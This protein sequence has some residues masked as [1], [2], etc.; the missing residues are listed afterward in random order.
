MVVKRVSHTTRLPHRT[1]ISKP[2]SPQSE[3]L[4]DSP[5]LLCHT[6]RSVSAFLCVSCIYLKGRSKEIDSYNIQKT[7]SEEMP[8]SPKG[9]LARLKKIF[10]AVRSL[11]LFIF[12]VFS[13][14]IIKVTVR[15]KMCGRPWPG[16]LRREGGV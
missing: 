4:P 2:R 16:G 7:M 15:Y 13:A 5:L 11:S 9:E 3:P 6:L 12:N 8:K 10:D 1:V 14:I